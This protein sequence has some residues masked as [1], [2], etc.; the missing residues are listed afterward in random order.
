MLYALEVV[1]QFAEG[2]TL[3]RVIKLVCQLAQDPIPNVRMIVA[4]TA[5]TIY[6]NIDS[7]SEKSQ[8]QQ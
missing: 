4:K 8:L 2:S 5:T 1:A 7:E 3:E 6:K